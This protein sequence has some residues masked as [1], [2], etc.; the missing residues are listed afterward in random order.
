M[1]KFKRIAALALG[2][3]TVLSTVAFANEDMIP[4][5][6]TLEDAGFVVTWDQETKAVTAAKDN[7]TITEPVGEN[8][9]LDYDKTY[10][11]EEFMQYILNQAMREELSSIATITSIGE[12]S[13]TANTEKLG[14]VVFMVDENTNI[15]HEMNRMLYT[16]ADLAE[17]MSIKVYY[18]EAMTASLPPQAYATEVVILNAVE[19][20]AALSCEAEVKE[21]GENFILA[22]TETLGE[23]M[24]MVDENT[25]I[26]HEMNRMFYTLKDVKVGDIV[27]VYYSEAMTASLPP[28]TYAT[29]V[30]VLPVVDETEFLG[31][32][33]TSC[34]I[35]SIGEDYFIAV[36]ADGTEVRFNVGEETFYHH[37]TNKML[38]RFESLIVGMDV[39][40]VHYQT[41]TFSLPPQYTAVEVT[42]Q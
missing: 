38:Y 5:R 11:T 12:N 16:F 30:V 6:E 13:F 27:K 10:A 18:S 41:A 3:I 8:I 17:N 7:F 40:V 19:A 34:K 42:I 25:N 35:E 15:H 37:T 29:E 26:H 22:D 4:V 2:A 9:I 24:F 31:T 20:E 33:T 14:E 32:A 23:V 1:N 36:T 21:I 39:E 28:Q